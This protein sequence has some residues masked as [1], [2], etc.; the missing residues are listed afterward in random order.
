VSRQVQVNRTMHILKGS[1][2]DGRTLIC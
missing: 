2:D 1:R